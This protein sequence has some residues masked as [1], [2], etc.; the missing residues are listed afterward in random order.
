M[1][2]LV[3]ICGLAGDGIVSSGE[4]LTSIINSIGLNVFNFRSYGAEIKARGLT[5]SQVRISDEP[6][7]SLG[8]KFDVLMSID[9][10]TSISQLADLKPEGILIYDNQPIGSQKSDESLLARV[11][12]KITLYGVPITLIS[13]KVMGTAR[14]KNVAA[15]GAFAYIAGLPLSGF[16]DGLMEKWGSKGEKVYKPNLEILRDGYNHA[17]ENLPLETKLSFKLASAG[18]IISG[19]EATV[20]G[21]VD[22]GCK[23]FSGYPITPASPIMEMLAKELPKH[24]GFVI[25]TEDEMAAIGTAIGSFFVGSRAMTAT[26][27]PGMSL[28][29][30]LINLSTMAE[31]PVV[32]VCA[33]RGGP[34]TGLPTKT[35]QSDLNLALFG[36]HGDS[37]RI[38][39]APTNAL[40]CYHAMLNAFDYAERYQLPVIVLTDFFLANRIESIKEELK[41]PKLVESTRVKP[42][43]DDLRDYRRYRI[44]EAGISP[45]AI[46]GEEYG[47]YTATGLE[48]DET[49][50]PAYTPE[51]H[52][53]MTDKRYAKLTTAAKE[54]S[55]VEIFGSEKP[56]VGII[57]WGST[58]GSILEAVATAME[59]GYPVAALKTMV[60][61]PL[62]EA[63]ISEFIKPLQKV[64]IPEGNFTGQFANVLSAKFDADFIRLNI[65]E[66]QPISPARIL[67]KIEEINH[68]M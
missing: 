56:E 53:A 3:Q 11:D 65:Y 22:A 35:E 1:D 21:A 12:P 23:V 49:G 41:P 66:G 59:K 47:Y 37:P 27:G 40:E 44:T 13:Q 30:E 36:A 54:I 9:N 58:V 31:T 45:W 38:V 4:I 64:I 48:H 29:V 67:A 55:R 34:S 42:T 43:Q 10:N 51:I 46:P 2:I 60:L 5:T 7:Y 33:Q 39:L 6:L 24:G 19:N 57:G 20:L 28:M 8:D 14:S 63:E 16:E 15:L 25:Q 61:N 18:Q 52:I 26:S 68:D 17:Q 32:L 62:A 50:K